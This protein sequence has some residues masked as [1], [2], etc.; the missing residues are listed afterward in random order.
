MNQLIDSP[1]I[2]ESLIISFE[3]VLLNFSFYNL[4]VFIPSPAFIMVLRDRLNK[5]INLEFEKHGIEIP[6]PQRHLHIKSSTLQAEEPTPVKGGTE[7]SDLQK[8]ATVGWWKEFYPKAKINMWIKRISISTGGGD[9]P[10]INAVFRVPNLD[11]LI[12]WK[13]SL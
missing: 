6:F 7:T 5:R 10:G 4:R 13:P 8:P 3:N 12:A 1:E 9:A 2:P 11:A